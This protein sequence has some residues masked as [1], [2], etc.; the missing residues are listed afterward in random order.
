MNRRRLLAGLAGGGVVGAGWGISTGSLPTDAVSTAEQ[1][2]A[3]I[4][5]E[6]IET[7]EAPGSVAG[8]QAIPAEGPLAVDFMSVTCS[9]CED[10]MPAL[11][12]AYEAYGESVS[13]LSVSTDPVGF[14]VEE[15]TLVEWWADHDGQWPL[16]V[17][18]Q[19][20]VTQELEVSAVPTTVLVD[21]DGRLVDRLR[22][23]KTATELAA[24][25]EAVKDT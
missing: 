5:G 24:M 14:S 2:D 13:F 16:G 25:I 22:G 4:V 7:V 12:E 23:E 20:S 9:V 21:E 11:V 8:E 10:S 1:A 17:D 18:S 19:L 15:S 6:R 3:D